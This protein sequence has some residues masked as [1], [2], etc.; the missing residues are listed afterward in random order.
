METSGHHHASSTFSAVVLINNFSS[1]ANKLVDSDSLGQGPS[2]TKK[3]MENMN[4]IRL[5]EKK[6]LKAVQEHEETLAEMAREE[7]S[8]LDELDSLGK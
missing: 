4:E 8:L 7:L 3:A 5:L 2:L 1:I 6:M